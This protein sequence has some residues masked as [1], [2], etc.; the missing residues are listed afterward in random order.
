MYSDFSLNYIQYQIQRGPVW[1]MSGLTRDGTV[2][3]LSRQTN[4]SSRVAF[5]EKL[6][7]A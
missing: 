7:R 6:E 2:E 5:K 4:A 3:P 1:R